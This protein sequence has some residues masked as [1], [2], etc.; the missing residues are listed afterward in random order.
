MFGHQALIKLSGTVTALEA[1]VIL[2][3]SVFCAVKGQRSARLFSGIFLVFLLA[4][5]TANLRRYG[6]VPNNV[7]TANGMQVG[8]AIEM[9]LLAYALADRFNVIRADR[10]SAQAEALEAQRRLVEGLRDSERI[11]E[12]RVD[13][14]TSEL[15]A[16]VTRLQQTQRDLVEAEKLASLGSLVAGVSHELNTP[17]GIALTAASTLEDGAREFKRVMNDEGIRRSTLE[18]FVQRSI[19]MGEL[20]VRSCHRAANL[21]SSFK[22]VAVDQTSEHRR[23]FDLL[24]LVNDN[25]TSLRPSLKNA[26]WT[27]EVDIPAGIQCDSYPGPLG[28]VLTNLIQNAGVHA[29]ED[30]ASGLLRISA[31]AHTDM[32]EL[33]I[34][35]NGQ[36]MSA[37]TLARIFE[38]FYTTKLGKGGSGLGLAICRNMVT[39]VLGG[40]LTATAQL[41]TG[42]QFVV[43]FPM[44]APQSTQN[45][46]A[47]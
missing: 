21:I 30:R 24:E 31:G 20:L 1:V 17:I 47:V 36:G 27:I 45:G 13:Q 5:I 41:G 16:T 43:R 18:T 32:V 35:D 6:V 37:P 42:S 2:C 23:V 44:V 15:S 22:Q 33:C 38:P 34:S 11:L 14:R 9:L 29:F 19:D 28:Q 8:S 39:G 40:Q 12:A 26:A 3:I 46:H 4:A 25:L 7:I 10:E